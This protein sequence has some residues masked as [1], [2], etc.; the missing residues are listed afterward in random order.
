M[1]ALTMK[2]PPTLEMDPRQ[3]ERLAAPIPLQD[4]S[5]GVSVQTQPMLLVQV[6]PKVRLTIALLLSERIRPAR[7]IR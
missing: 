1:K 6:R 7:S 4:P 3:R 2:G 5:T